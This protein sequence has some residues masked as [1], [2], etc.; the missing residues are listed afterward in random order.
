[1]NISALHT[2][3]L[4]ARVYIVVFML[5]KRYTVFTLEA[6]L[7]SKFDVVQEIICR[8]E[9]PPAVPNSSEEVSENVVLAMRP[10]VGTVHCLVLTHST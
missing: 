1:M 8:F 2:G 5:K 9:H 7:V 10:H 3:G 4:F 6:L